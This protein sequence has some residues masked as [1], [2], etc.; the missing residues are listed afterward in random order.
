[1][2]F[3]PVCNKTEIE[4]IFN[5]ATAKDYLLKLRAETIVDHMR[6]FRVYRNKALANEGHWS[7]E[8]SFGAEHFLAYLAALSHENR[9]RCQD[10]TYGNMFSN[11]PNGTI[12]ASPYGPIITISESLEFFLTFAHLALMT[13]ECDVPT[14]VRANALRI[15]VRVM[16]QTEALDFLMDP[17]GILPHAVRETIHA[18]LSLEMEFIAGHEFAHYLLGHI[19]S[20][21]VI[22]K[23]VFRAITPKDD[24]YKLV[25]VYSQSQQDELDAD[26]GAIELVETDPAHRTA[27]LDAALLWF[28]CLDLYETVEEALHPTIHWR[29]PSHPSAAVR[30]GHLLNNATKSTDYDAARW[31]TLM[32]T[33]GAYKQFLL[34]DVSTNIDAYESY[35]SVYLDKPDTPWRGKKLTDRVDYF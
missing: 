23:A 25:P 34:E 8:Q 21:A 33:I 5:V 19:S 1:M 35:G 2:F 31:T 30:F 14:H 26:L 7:L 16:L 24:D 18:P 28:A 4:R 3:F 12:F 15:A 29:L 11:D 17:R 27:L 22:D 9:T 6:L 10:I 32:N 20:G 13:F